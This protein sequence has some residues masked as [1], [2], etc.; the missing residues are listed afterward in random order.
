MFC[1]L[2][3]EPFLVGEAALEAR[4]ESVEGMRNV[5][6]PS[7]GGVPFATCGVRERKRRKTLS[8]FLMRNSLCLQ[9]KDL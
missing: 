7:G 9:S 3:L 4:V 6:S 8:E 5:V 2:P 1:L